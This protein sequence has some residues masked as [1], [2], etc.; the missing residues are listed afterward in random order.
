MSGYAGSHRCVER[1]LSERQYLIVGYELLDVVRLGDVTQVRLNY[2]GT[3]L[4]IVE[5]SASAPANRP[6]YIFID[7]DYEPIVRCALFESCEW[8]DG[9]EPRRGGAL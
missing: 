8:N 9:T 1:P 7:D 4:F 2:T 6:V 5:V 3:G